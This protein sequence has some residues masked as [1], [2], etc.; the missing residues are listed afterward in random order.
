MGG[1]RDFRM[2]EHQGMLRVM[3]T[4]FIN[5]PADFQDHR[6]FVLRPKTSELALEVVSTLPNDA[7]PEELGKPNEGLFGVRFMGDRAYAVT[8]R[9]IDP[10][11]VIDLANPADPR[12]AGNSGDSRCF[13]IPAPG[14]AKTCC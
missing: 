9:Q 12:I 10:L 3:T 5:D 8:F 1:Q 13:R 7:R 6:L 11:Y 4:E 2:S 14:D